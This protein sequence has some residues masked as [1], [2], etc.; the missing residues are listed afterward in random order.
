MASKLCHT[1]GLA[2]KPCHTMSA[3]FL[4]RLR[5]KYD[6]T[7][8]T[9]ALLIVLWLF[10]GA[11]LVYP[12]VYVFSQAFY[13]N[14]R[15]SL[16]FFRLMLADTVLRDCVI[17]SI[18]VGA[19]ATVLTTIIGLPLAFV[20]TRRRFRGKGLLQALVLVPMV[21]PPFVGAIGMRQ[22]FARF[23]SINLALMKLGI[24][25]EPVDWFGGGGFVGVVIL[26]AL[27][28]YPIMYLNIAAALA[29][30]DPSMEEAAQNLGA[31]PWKLFR[32][33]TF[34]LMLPGYFAGA[35]IV[36]IW[37]F[38]DL[39][40]PLI[41]QYRTVVP[42]K[43]F[44]NVKDIH[45]N[46]MGYALV[47]LVIVMT[48]LFF[49]VAKRF[50]GERR[51]EM[52]G[53]GHVAEREKPLGR[54]G[55]ILAL[56]GI[57][58]LIGIALLPHVSVLLTSISAKWF[59]TVVPEKVSLTYYGKVFSHEL[60]LPSI[61][62]SLLFSSFST[63]L[64]VVLGV[65]IAYLLTRRRIPGQNLLDAT[66]MLPLALPGI[67][68]AFG[69]VASF[70]DTPL[71]PRQNPTL[72]LIIAYGVRR[73]P[74]AVRAAYA[75]FQQTSVA[76]EEASQ[77]LGASP[78]TT[79]RRITFPLISAN[80]VAG[81]I[82]A[83]SFAMLEVSDSLILAMKEQYYPIT[84]AIFHLMQRIADGPFIASAMGMLGM[85]LL[86]VSLVAAGR[87]LGARM[88]QLFRA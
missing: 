48:M 25:S 70:A 61:R 74:Y 5:R 41:F 31:G 46:P 30:V 60:T 11:F 38:T 81:A 21:M 54:I 45:T 64:D 49:Y 56:V 4:S 32:T 84:K 43:I 44:D 47:V 85:A 28:L 10:F 59:M 35:V 26:E 12:L 8:G 24:I 53:R 71:D 72:L 73:L 6:L 18:N 63:V 2:S 15:F 16:T 51:Y 40:T 52:M 87:F 83:F 37:A 22:F 3:M 66:A 57:L 7:G 39:G 82:L 69:Y 23:G 79:L 68:L 36:F 14:G 86:T 17:N 33:I 65:L 80:L 1:V 78:F 58:S 76:L 62:N 88:G 20:M 50:V 27:H 9:T 77:N 34:P 67:V 19:A 42:V 75:G 13:V 29:N 55:T